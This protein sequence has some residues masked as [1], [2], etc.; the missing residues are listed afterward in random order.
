[1]SISGPLRQIIFQSSSGSRRRRSMLP[2]LR[3][4]IF[5]F[6][7]LPSDLVEVDQSNVR[8]IGIN[9]T[10]DPLFNG[11][12]YTPRN[13]NLSV[14]GRFPNL[15][16]HGYLEPLDRREFPTQR[17]RSLLFKLQFQTV[18]LDDVYFS[19]FVVSYGSPAT[20]RWQPCYIFFVAPIICMVCNAEDNIYGG[21]GLSNYCSMV[22]NNKLRAVL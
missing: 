22:L 12:R 8:S 1:M 19:I 14:H 9:S 10:S 15:L 5:F 17:F 21:S 2:A 13:S 4:I 18:I 20:C 7:V 11:R 6:A 16:I 3:Q